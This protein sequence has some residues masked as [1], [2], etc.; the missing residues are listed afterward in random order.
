MIDIVDAANSAVDEIQNVYDTLHDA[1]DEF[2]ANE[3]F[4]T[5]DT[6]QA[7]LSLGPQYMQMLEDENGLWQIN[8]ERINDVIA[9][10]TRQLA[11]ENAMAYVERIKIAAMEGSE[12]QLNSL[13]FATTE[14]TN[15]TWGLVYAELD[16]MRVM[17]ELS[18]S[19][20]QAAVHNIDAMRD[21]AENAVE[22]IGKATGAAEDHL[23]EMRNQ[24]EETKKGLE[25]TLDELEKME[26]DAGKLIDYVMEMLK[27]RIEQQI[28]LLEEMKDKYSEIIDLKKESLDATKDEQ[29][30]QKSIANKLRELAKLQE[31]INALSL[32]D[33]REAQAERAG[34]LEE[35]AELQEELNE[36][37]ADKALEIQKDSLDEMEEEYHAEKDKEIEILRESISSKQKLWDMAIDYIRNHWNTLYSELIA[38]NTEYGSSLNIEISEA[39][40]AAQAAAQRY[41]DYVS[42]IMGGISAEIDSI[43]QQ[44]KSLDEQIANLSTSSSSGSTSGSDSSSGDKNLTVGH[45]TEH[46]APTNREMVQTIVGRMKEYAAMWDPYDKAGKNDE[47]HAKAV[48]AAGML[49]GYDVSAEYH[50][51]DGTWWIRKD[52]LNPGNVGK[53]LFDCYH[54]GGFVGDE[55]LKPNE[56]Y[57]RAEN[58]ELMLT[59]DQQDSLAA[60]LERINAIADAFKDLSKL[61]P[62]FAVMDRLSQDERGLVDG[63]TGAPRPIEISIGDTIIQGN[64]SPDT[65]QQHIK[66]TRDMVNQI[67]RL[68]GV[69]M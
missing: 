3:G 22:S 25:E 36:T 7:L 31:R 69:K 29:D 51:A 1:A 14:A 64:A 42:A 45:K 58:G 12:E 5:V 37:Q 34:L 65:V 35:M 59:R 60:Q 27:H 18:E 23:E 66:V 62:A 56:R 13:I 68:V 9:A 54:T 28:D 39:W 55:P 48:K 19:Q 26:D 11:V 2:A 57:I 49:E 43:T 41:G 30:Y 52:L 46:A 16:Y 17:G 21:L 63:V 33:S 4:I 53:L 38:W 6:Y 15:S 67:A 47:L 8:E 10:R 40:E 44:I 24:L 20:Y 50:P 32:D 61:A